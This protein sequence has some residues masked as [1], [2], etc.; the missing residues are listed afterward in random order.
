MVQHNTWAAFRSVMLKR[1][2]RDFVFLPWN[3]ERRATVRSKQILAS[4]RIRGIAGS[5]DRVLSILQERLFDLRYGTDTVAW[6]DLDSLTIDSPHVAEAVRYEPMRLRPLRRV[7]SALK[8]PLDG[9]FVEIGCGKGRVLLLAADYGFQRII[10]IEFAKELCS[11]ARDNVA[12]YRRKTG[13]Q[14]DI[15]IIEGDAVDYEVQDND[16]VFFVNNP[17]GAA[18]VE[19]LV[20]N[21]VQSLAKKG[22]QVFIIYHNPRWHA[23]MEQQGFSPLLEIDGGDCVVYSNTT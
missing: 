23:V 5:L 8:P 6:A 11:I 10:G 1:N 20:Q 22:R 16:N 14:S 3:R 17:F 9:T 7:M 4:L 12:R 18:L 13:I 21:I 2:L 19:R 15:R